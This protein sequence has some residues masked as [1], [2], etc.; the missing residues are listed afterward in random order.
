[1]NKQVILI[2]GHNNISRGAY[3]V[4]LSMTEFEY[5]SKVVELLTDL[6]NVK[7]LFRENKQSYS[8]EMADLINRLD[9]NKYDLALEL[10]F[11][12]AIDTN[13]GGTETLVYYKNIKAKQYSQL[14]FDKIKEYRPTQKI[15]GVK[16]VSTENERGAYGIVKSKGTYILL[17]AFFGS[18]KE[19]VISV[20]DYANI[21]RN[22]IKEVDNV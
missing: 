16:T 15:R 9:I 6:P 20:E 13:I 22:F 11:N 12:S 14:Y 10:H 1:M 2:V 19:D 18:N 8:K 17:E 3:S 7:V 5:H 21:L 4:P